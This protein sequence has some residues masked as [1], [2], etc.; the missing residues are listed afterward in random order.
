M[1]GEAVVDLRELLSETLVSGLR[2]MVARALG[3]EDDVSDAVQQ[4]LANA[5]EAARNG[6]IPPTVSPV[7]YIHGIARHVIADALKRR[8]RDRRNEPLEEFPSLATSP[9]D[10]LI[11]EEEEAMVQRAL[12]RL[13]S[14]DRSLLRRCYVHGERVAD[15]A[16]DL[17][18]PAAR[19]RKRKSRAL[20]VLRPVVEECLASHD[21]TPGETGEV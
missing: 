11:R 15:I 9:L 1:H 21:S 20:A 5:I 13:P 2:L 10:V 14:R 18:E 4:I 7:A 6:R 16:Q 12:E 3:D 19:V 17:G 8:I